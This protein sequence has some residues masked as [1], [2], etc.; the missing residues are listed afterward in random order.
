VVAGSCGALVGC[1]DH[2]G[3][4]PE[5]TAAEREILDLVARGHSNAEIAR[6]LNPGDKT[7]RNHLSNSLTE[8]QLADRAHAIVRAREAGLG[9]P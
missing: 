5:L 3:V 2:A 8:R 1:L 9:K 6:V 7:V 4:F